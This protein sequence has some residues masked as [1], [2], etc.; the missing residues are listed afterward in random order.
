MMNGSTMPV[1]LQ[2]RTIV[3]AAF[4]LFVASP[5]TE[6]TEWQWSIEVK[7]GRESAG[8]ARAFLWIPADCRRV[9]GVVL[10]QHN[11][12]EIQILENPRFRRA[13]SELGFAEVWCSPPFDHLFR[14]NEG[15]GD[16]FNGMMNDLAG[17]SG[18]DELK[19]A[20]I[21]GIGH[22]AAA[23]WPYYFAA[24]DPNRA[25]A[26]IS[27][28]GQWPY[29]RDR[30]TFAPDIWGDRTI[31]YI[32]S[33]ETMGEYEAANTWS[34]EGLRE[35]QQHPLMPLS[36]LAAP[37]EGHFASSD[38]KVE[39]LVLYIKKAVQYRMPQEAP[40]DGPSKLKPI[41]PTRTGWLVDKWRFNQPPTAPAAPVGQ[42][43]GDPA[44]AFWFFD[45]EMAKATEAY[46]AAYR[47]MK[48]QLVGYVQDGNAVPQR[49]T[50][51]QVSLRFE[52]LEDGVT[53]RLTGAFYD[54][55]PGGSPRLATWSGLSAGSP[56]GHATGGTPIS[57]DRI[58]GPFEKLGPDTFAFRLGRGLGANLKSYELCFAATHPGDNE[59]KPA[60]QQ[61]NMI[62]PIRNAEGAEQ[63]IMFPEIPTQKAG[64]KSVKLGAT[65]DSGA[66]VYY[67]V[68]E[69]PAEVDGD[70]LTFTAIPP[71]SKYPVRVTVVAW[72]YGRASEPKLRTAV[73]L[74]RTFSI[75][76]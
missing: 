60:V 69:G 64:T 31:D 67:Y 34:T 68:R 57:I 62:L 10:A 39:Y 63:H 41:D 2:S 53:F 4:C 19:Y 36:M 32:P 28:S 9:R 38:K 22:S 48:P 65:C 54:T 21:V 59:Y 75:V 37:A 15:A 74:E 14:F 27:V 55:V 58:C 23:S 24:W 13:L 66:K 16:T 50:H 71:R 51:L 40:L 29:V 12:E 73:P 6:A 18:Y 35:R 17:Q 11:M 25:L 52:P 26:A 43:A 44:Q 42:Y 47:G 56:I 30:G 3:L 7:G 72:Q 1:R 5:R 8:P 46:Q 33:L 70:M 61:A 76:K 49:N 45:E 20:P